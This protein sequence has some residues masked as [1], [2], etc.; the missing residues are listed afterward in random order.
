MTPWITSNRPWFGSHTRRQLLNRK[1][2]QLNVTSD[3]STRLDVH[4]TSVLFRDSSTLRARRRAL[5]S[6]V[7]GPAAG[8]RGTAGSA[9]GGNTVLAEE[10]VLLAVSTIANAGSSRGTSSG[11]SRTWP[12]LLALRQR[13]D[14]VRELTPSPCRVVSD[15]DAATTATGL[16]GA[17]FCEGLGEL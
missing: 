5:D 7:T 11:S 2:D 8:R 12:E 4:G 17:G 14:R 9:T 13:I 15:T 3:K 16:L 6:S 10:T 1:L